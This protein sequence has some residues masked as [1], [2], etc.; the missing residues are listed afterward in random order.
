MIRQEVA[1]SGN[2]ITAEALRHLVFLWQKS[3]QEVW[4]QGV[5]Q[6]GLKMEKQSV[7]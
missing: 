2:G 1:Q 5:A 7:K 3:W 4:Q 6:V